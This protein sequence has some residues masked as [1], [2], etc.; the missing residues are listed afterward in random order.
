MPSRA[1]RRLLLILLTLVA[2]I[3]SAAD[4]DRDAVV[5]AAKNF[6]VVDPDEQ[7]PVD[8]AAPKAPRKYDTFAHHALDIDAGEAPVSP[9]KYALLDAIIDDVKARVTYDAGLDDARDRR[10]HAEHVLK[11]ID[12]VLTEHNVLYPPGDCDVVSLRS[13]L[14]PQRLDD[15][16]LKAALRVGV[17]A[18]RREHALRHKDEPFHILDCDT[19]GILYVGVAQAL[20]FDGLHLVDLPDHMFVRWDLGDGKHLNWDTNEAVEVSD[21]DF[22][23][24]YGLGKRLR[25]QRV[26]LSSM[27]A[28]EAEGFVY[29]LRAARFQERDEDTKAIADLEK[30]RELYPQA[31]QV[32][33]DLAWL[34][35]TAANV[36][37]VH[38][39]EALDLARAA[40]KLEPKFA[41]FH[42][43]LAAAYAANGDFKKAVA[44]SLKAEQYAETPDER[45]EFRAH[46]KCFER[47][48]M[49]RA[50][51]APAASNDE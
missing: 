22:V 39:K 10:R 21:R 15:A 27:T 38:R 14:A 37:A 30:A 51:R 36:D 49:P 50:A 48:V 6:K 40:L 12:E 44:A 7:R 34:Y 32:W 18:R 42:D 47:G 23:K 20:G 11:T 19:G 46:R 2:P 5:E 28:R 29:F 3:A 43:S 8:P 25:K 24:D 26:Y 13:G 17:N 1:P 35:A 31:T 9:A 41:D 45:D 16:T 33:G 4:R